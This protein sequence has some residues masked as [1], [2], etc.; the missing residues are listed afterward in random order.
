MAKVKILV[1]IETPVISDKKE[2]FAIFRP[3]EQQYIYQEQ[4]NTLTKI[5]LQGNEIRRENKE[6]SMKYIFDEQKESTGYFIIKELQKK[7]YLT[8]KTERIIRYQNNIEITYKL[9]NELYK[10][11]LEVI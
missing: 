7:L 10:Y 9:D 5:Y 1:T 8:I 3:E 2:Y 6:M 11:K 4:D